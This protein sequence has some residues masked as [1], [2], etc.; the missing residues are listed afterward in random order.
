MDHT[1]VPAA[2][3]R[4]LWAARARWHEW[5]RNPALVGPAGVFVLSRVLFLLLT[6]F[7]VVLFHPT[8]YPHPPMTAPQPSLGHQLLLSWQRWDTQWYLDIAQRGYAWRNPAGTTPA[9]FFPLYPALIH[10]GVVLTHRSG[11]AVALLISNLAFLGALLYLW[12]LTAWELGGEVAGRA[13]LYLAVFPS[14]FFFFA[15]YTESLFLLLSVASFYYFR[16]QAWLAAGLFGGLAAT[17]RVT[18]VLLALPFFYEYARVHNFSPRRM[19]QPALPAVLL[20]PLGVVLFMAYLA[21]VAGNPLAF[22]LGQQ[23]WQKAFTPRL[24]LGLTDTLH[25]LLAEPFASYFEAHNLINLAALLLFLAGTVLVARRLPAAYTLYL[26]AFWLVTLVSP[27]TAGGY[28]V[29]LVSMERYVLSLFPVFMVLALLGR[30]PA[31]HDAYLVLGTGLLA[32]LTV[33]F[34][35]GWWIV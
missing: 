19:L 25:H 34:V 14:A 9:A 23:A 6:Y 8:V 32:L 24:W 26:L 13:I 2:R 29:P 10:L 1:A 5:A 15:G 31:V 3:S 30:R 21:R 27:A 12:R 4:P 18:G 22:S 28:P 33:Q 20:I 35:N 11:L 7:G 17:T 16:R